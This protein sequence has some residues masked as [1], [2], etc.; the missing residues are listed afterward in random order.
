MTDERRAELLEPLGDWI[1]LEG[2]EVRP[3]DGEPYIFTAASRAEQEDKPGTFGS[4]NG[5]LVAIDG[6]GNY[7][8]SPSSKTRIRQL[9][10]AGYTP[11]HISVPMSNGERFVFNGLNENKEALDRQTERERKQ[12][13]DAQYAAAAEQAGIS[14]EVDG[15]WLPVDDLEI[16]P[17]DGDPYVRVSRYDANEAQ[18]RLEQVGTYDSNNGVI[19]R[20]DHE[21]VVQ[22]APATQENADALR[23]AGYEYG[24][25]SVP[26]SNLDTPTGTAEKAKWDRMTE[27]GRKDRRKAA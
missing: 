10:D 7:W 23:R 8:I 4:N 15:E 16:K 14:P 19:A 1:N 9:R 5:T 22:V 25:L 11:E 20:V 18:K 27:E 24:P 21:G 26:L 6:D 2:R 3:L 12:E 13:L 17:L